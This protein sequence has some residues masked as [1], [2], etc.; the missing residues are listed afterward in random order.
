MHDTYVLR[1][2]DRLVLGVAAIVVSLPAILIDHGVGLREAAFAQSIRE[3]SQ[4]S[5]WL[6]PTIG[7]LPWITA[8]PLTQWFAHSIASIFGITNV[9]LAVRMAG[10]L[11]AILATQWTASFAT[12]CSGRRPGVLAGFVLLTTLGVAENIWHGGHVMWLVAAGSGFMNLLASLECLTPAQGNAAGRAITTSNLRVASVPRILIVFALLGLTTLI[13]GP[14]AA[15]VTILVPAA[16][17]VLWRSEFK[18]RLRNPWLVGWLVLAAGAAVWPVVTTLNVM[19]S[20]GFWLST[21]NPLTQHRQPM[22]QLWELL[23]MSLPW[24]PLAIFGQWCIRHDAFAG[25]YSRERLLA[26][27]SI[28]VPVAAFLLT[29][30]SMVFAV[31]AAGAWSVSAAIGVERLALRIFSELPMLETRHNRAILQKFLAASAAVLTLSIVWNDLGT[32]SR[33]VDRELLAKAGAVA[34]QQPGRPLR[35]DMNLGDHAAVLLFELGDRAA[36]LQV[37]ELT[38]A[39][40]AAVVITSADRPEFAPGSRVAA[41]LFESSWNHH[42]TILRWQPAGDAPATRIAAEPGKARF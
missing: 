12:A 38:D 42:P 30:S 9:L 14:L 19:E 21:L 13:A 3:M 11:P 33:Q 40:H 20:S 41:P 6:I 22:L 8:S 36:P 34:E 35:I 27:W 31:A 2:R 7:G 5:Q 1:F 26:C 23:Q 17:H 39:G 4:S 18:R 10:V 28:S 24:L 29:P 37:M 25:S 15:F 16:G 32:D